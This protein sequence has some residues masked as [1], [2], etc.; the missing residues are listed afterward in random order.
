MHAGVEQDGQAHTMCS[1]LE[2]TGLF[3][4]THLDRRPNRRGYASSGF[5]L[6]VVDFARVRRLRRGVGVD[7][8]L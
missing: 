2:G 4:S 7:R 1:K 3:N 8:L 5:R 6:V